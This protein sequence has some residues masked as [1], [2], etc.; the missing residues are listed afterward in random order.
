MELF[1][2]DIPWGRVVDGPNPQL[3]NGPYPR[4]NTGSDIGTWEDEERILV[5]S[6]TPGINIGGSCPLSQACHNYVIICLNIRFSSTMSVSLVV[7]SIRVS[8]GFTI[9]SVLVVIEAL[10]LY[11]V[12]YECSASLPQSN[13]RK[14]T[15]VD[16]KWTNLL[17]VRQF[18]KSITHL[19]IT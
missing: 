4:G 2:N 16:V 19:L 5:I 8:A 18:Y 3:S 10:T 11:L 6:R 1:L 9:V 17:G 12:K 15:W 13:H 14:L 7:E